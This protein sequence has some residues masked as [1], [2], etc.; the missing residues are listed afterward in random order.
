MKYHIFVDDEMRITFD[1]ENDH[2]DGMCVTLADGVILN[3]EED[4]VEDER[5]DVPRMDETFKEFVARYDLSDPEQ[6]AYLT[7]MFMDTKAK[8]QEKLED[9]GAMLRLSEKYLAVIAT[10][11]RTPTPKKRRHLR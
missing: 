10:G 1:D 2:T 7:S 6:R 4:A 3:D 9:H 8:A 11:A 5:L